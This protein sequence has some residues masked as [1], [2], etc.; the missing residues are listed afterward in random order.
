MA[1]L[2]ISATSFADFNGIRHS[3]AER[4]PQKKLLFPFPRSYFIWSIYRYLPRCTSGVMS[5]VRIWYTIAITIT[6]EMASPVPMIYTP[7]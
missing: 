5:A 7:L 3:L 1:V 2:V 6:I 4:T